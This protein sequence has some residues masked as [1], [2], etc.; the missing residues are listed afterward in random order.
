MTK[1]VLNRLIS[2]ITHGNDERDSES[3]NLGGE[4]NESS[5]TTDSGRN[6]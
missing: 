4:A 1:S 5:S 2:S 6:G 3:D